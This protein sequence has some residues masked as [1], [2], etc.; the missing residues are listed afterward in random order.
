LTA[1]VV[2]PRR[3]WLSTSLLTALLL[4]TSLLV[5]AGSAWADGPPSDLAGYGVFYNRYEPTFYTGFAP[6]TQDP[7]RL[8]LHVGRGNQLRVTLVLSDAVIQRYVDDLLARYHGYRELIDSG[9]LKLTQNRAFEQFEQTVRDRDLE[10]LQAEQRKLSGGETRQRNLRLMRE[11]NPERIFSIRYSEQVLLDHWRA[12]LNDEDRRGTNDRRRLWLLNQML[13]N[14]LWIT[15]TDAATRSAL[16]QLINFSSDDDPGWPEAFFALLDQLSG[17]IYPRRD[18]SVQFD[19][20]TALYPI[21]TFNEY[22]PDPGPLDHDDPPA[23]QNTGP[24]PRQD[25][26]QLLAVVAVHARRQDHA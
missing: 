6:R 18:G 12:Q 10:T 19:E 22:V 20:F 8:H 16:K 14:R 9:R 17:G 15:T 1:S 5:L 25:H 2:A 23:H 7:K 21:G 24:H 11:L 4:G 26:L 3:R 13:P